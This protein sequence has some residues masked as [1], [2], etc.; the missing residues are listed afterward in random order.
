MIVSVGLFLVGMMIT[1]VVNARS[2]AKVEQNWDQTQSSVD[3]QAERNTLWD[4]DRMGKILQ[5]ELDK[6]EAAK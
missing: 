2:T 5:K 3:V 1:T 4:P 6:V